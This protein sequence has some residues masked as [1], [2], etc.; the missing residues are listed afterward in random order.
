MLVAGRVYRQYLPNPACNPLKP[1]SR[2]VCEIFPG[3]R[4][5]SGKIEVRP[6]LES[7]TGLEQAGEEGGLADPEG[8]ANPIYC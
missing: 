1:I 4:Q 5:N 2:I 7:R 6:G 8:P 3:W